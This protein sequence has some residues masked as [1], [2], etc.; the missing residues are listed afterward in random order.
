[1]SKIKFKF[2]LRHKNP[3]DQIGVFCGCVVLP[4]GQRKTSRNQDALTREVKV[5]QGSVLCAEGA[6]T[7]GSFPVDYKGQVYFPPSIAHWNTN[8][9]DVE[10]FTLL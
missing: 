10:L 9:E 2:L 5:F 7:S 8:E 1:L 4:N 6:A 3:E